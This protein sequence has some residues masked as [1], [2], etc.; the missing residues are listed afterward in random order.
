M[1][2]F[3][4]RVLDFE[5]ILT[6]LEELG[7]G[8]TPNLLFRSLLIFKLG[9]SSVREE[10]ESFPRILFGVLKPESDRILFEAEFDLKFFKY[11]KD[12]S[13][14]F[15]I[16]E[17][18]SAVRIA[19]P[20]FSWSLWVFYRSKEMQSC[21]CEAEYPVYFSSSGLQLYSNPINCLDTSKVEAPITE[22]LN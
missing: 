8:V 22:G 4:S 17:K 2:E 5:V 12:E 10:D 9:W 19:L 13:G 1:F 11:S 18:I 7:L 6:T 14:N 3:F 16:K 15:L 20:E 21:N